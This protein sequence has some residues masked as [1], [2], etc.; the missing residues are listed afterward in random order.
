MAQ[1]TFLLCWMRLPHR[2]I[3]IMLNPNRL[4]VTVKQSLSNGQTDRAWE[5]GQRMSAQRDRE[6]VCVFVW[7]ICVCVNMGVSVHVCESVCMRAC[8]VC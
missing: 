1:Q 4:P 6:S 3:I 7:M 2:N 5:M 8:V